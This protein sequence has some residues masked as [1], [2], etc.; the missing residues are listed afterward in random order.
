MELKL[1]NGDYVPDGTGSVIRLE[2]EQALL[3]RVLFRLKAH[4]GSFPFWHELGS[5]RW[6]LGRLPARERQ[7][8]AKQYVTEALSAEPGLRV[9]SVELSQSGDGSGALTVGLSCLDEPLT[10]MLELHE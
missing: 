5:R 8:A 7:T 6:Q 4:R 3:Q 9:E 1:R 2:G 10:V